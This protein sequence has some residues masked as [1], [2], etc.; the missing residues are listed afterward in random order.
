MKEM[1]TPECGRQIAIGDAAALAE[2][3]VWIKG[4]DDATRARMA[5]AGRARVRQHY[6][7]AGQAAAMTAAIEQ[8]QGRVACA[9]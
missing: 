6:T 7:L 8:M 9:A 4:L 1:V 5:A 2:A 3:L